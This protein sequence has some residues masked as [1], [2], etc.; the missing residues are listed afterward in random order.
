MAEHWKITPLRVGSF[1]LDGGAMFGVIPRFIWS[2]WISPDENNRIPLAVR[3]LLLELGDQR[4]L[5]EAGY[6]DKWTERERTIYEMERRTVVDALTEVGTSPP[7]ISL[8]IVTHLH[9]DHVGGL[10][11]APADRAA[12]PSLTPEECRP[13]FPRARVVVQRREWDDALANR[14][15]MARTYLPANLLPLHDQVQLVEGT[16]EILP[17]LSVQP[18]GGHTPGQQGVWIQTESGTVVFP[19][20]LLP[21]RHHAHLSA[22]LGYDMSSW[23]TMQT[24]KAFLA[25]ARAENW[26][27]ALDHD[28]DFPLTMVGAD[29]KGRWTLEPLCASG[30]APILRA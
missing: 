5:V 2:H 20:D 16:A 18:L 10:T 9:F 30:G 4:V 12:D 8:V 17:G 26:Q 19:G 27:V 22:S 13:T 23:E 11:R 29:A 25:Q 1:R 15:I 3:A 21:T 28:P 6:G 7:D 24:K 14:S